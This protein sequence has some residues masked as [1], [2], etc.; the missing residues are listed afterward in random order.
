MGLCVEGVAGVNLLY[1]LGGTH[2]YWEGWFD[3][4]DEDRTEKVAKIK[5]KTAERT[6]PGGLTGGLTTGKSAKSRAY[7]ASAHGRDVSLAV[8]ASVTRDWGHGHMGETSLNTSGRCRFP[9]QSGETD[10]WYHGIVTGLVGQKT[11][12][13]DVSLRT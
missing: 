12:N 11:L 8:S 6:R 4:T 2:K 7:R 1:T 3:R 9:R 10:S 5:A 13:K